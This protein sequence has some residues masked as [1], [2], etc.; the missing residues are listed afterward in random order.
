MAGLVP[1]KSHHH[2]PDS[3]TSEL[4]LSVPPKL[5]PKA[6]ERVDSVG[7]LW[8]APN[9]CKMKTHTFHIP[10]N[11][12]TRFLSDLKSKVSAFEVLSALI[13]KSMSKINENPKETSKGDHSWYK[14]IPEKRIRVSK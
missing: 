8:L 11:K 2:I 3:A 9:N 7:D 12:I 1:H 10:A 4:N 6:L 14:Q 5:T 13:W